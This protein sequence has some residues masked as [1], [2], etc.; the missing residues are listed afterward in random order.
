MI[1]FCCTLRS[2][3]LSEDKVLLVASP[4]LHPQGCFTK[5]YFGITNTIFRKIP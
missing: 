1:Q 2:R 4:K 5:L 3:N